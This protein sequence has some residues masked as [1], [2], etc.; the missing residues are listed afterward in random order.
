MN[1]AIAWPEDIDLCIGA[2]SSV[3]A[4]ALLLAQLWPRLKIV[5]SIPGPGMGCQS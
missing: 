5:C 4:L 3:R 2:E 1:P